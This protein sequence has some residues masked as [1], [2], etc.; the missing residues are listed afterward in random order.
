MLTSLH[1]FLESFALLIMF[2]LGIISSELLVTWRTD[3]NWMRCIGRCYIELMTSLAFYIL[4]IIS[5]EQYDFCRA[6]W[7]VAGTGG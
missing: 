5:N 2:Q 4:L 3:K 6:A 7:Q 1:L